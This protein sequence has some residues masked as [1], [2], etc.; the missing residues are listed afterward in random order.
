MPPPLDLMIYEKTSGS[1]TPQLVA[2]LSLSGRTELGRQET[3]A[4]SLYTSTW[5][6]EEGYWR[7][8]IARG[9]EQTIGRHH[10][11][12]EF[13]PDGRLQLTNTSNRSTVQLEN[14]PS[15]PRSI[16]H[17]V[18]MP[19]AG[20]VMRLGSSRVVRLQSR[21]EAVPSEIWGLPEATV[22]PE[23]FSKASGAGRSVRLTL[24]ADPA[25]EN[26][27]LVGWLQMALGLLQS[28]ANSADF[29]PRAAQAVVDLAGME[30]GRVLL[31]NETGWKEEASAFANGQVQD[32]S[33]QPSQRIVGRVRAEKKTFWELP[34]LTA[35]GSVL[36]V[37]AVVAAPILDPKEEVIGILYGDRR[38]LGRPINRI[39]AMLIEL[40]ACGVASRLARLKE[41]QA[42]LRF[43]QF[44][45]PR[46]ARQLVQNPDLLAGRLAFVTLLFCDVRGFSRF[47]QR[48][49]PEIIVK[50]ISDVMGTLSDCVIQYEGT[51]VDYIGDELMAMW[52][53]PEPQSNHAQ[54]ACQAALA[55]LAQ[56]PVLNARWQPTLR[57]PMSFGIGLNSGEAHV[58]NTGTVRKFKYGPL[59]NT[60]NL[61]SRVQGATKHLRSRLLL[62]K[63]T[64]KE[65][66]PEMQARARRLCMVRV[67]N[68]DDVVELFELAPPDQH[69]W[70]D[71]KEKYE[72]SLAE[73]D[74]MN[75]RQAAR[76]LQPLITEQVNDGP[77]I[78]LMSRAVQG[79][80]N[81]PAPGHPVW[82]LPSK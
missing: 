27:A 43:E 38:Q 61:A 10:V 21:Q 44:F 54:L 80:A 28:A 20:L 18:E 22:A 65:L 23:N 41:E 42:M 70:P 81:G 75:F 19:A 59:G 4:E 26:E 7:V 45:S 3:T 55:M 57:E 71:W 48:L 2:T 47:S 14:G 35:A 5:R 53:A 50:W 79:L 15:L 39:E 63:N 78:V 37:Q 30:S 58:G 73:F 40:L 52:G 32:P 74:R 64:Y 77:S 60:V 6:P 25:I 82:E 56:L 49:K 8:V 34:R 1:P 29:F 16:P 69:P 17:A 67:V 33:W 11:L 68:I 46:L 24:P 76:A 31:F 72:T 12:L 9:T 13:L 66:T 62:T 51:L 36:G